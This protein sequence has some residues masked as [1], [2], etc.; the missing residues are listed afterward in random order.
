MVDGLDRFTDHFKGFSNAYVLIGGAA[1]DLWL[2]DHAL[3]FRATRDL[4]LVLLVEALTPPFFAR[5]W[6]FIR[7][8]QYRSLCETTG[9]PKF[10]RFSQPRQTGYPF[11]IELLTRNH[12][13]LPPGIK[14]TPIPAG[15]E[16]SS[17]SA[18]LMDDEYYQFVLNSRIVIKNVPLV[19]AN[20][21]IP[22][23]ARA[24]LDLTARRA[25][26]DHL[27]KGTDIKK[28][29]NDVFRLYRSLAPAERF[30]LP[31]RPRA[32]LQS[33]LDHFPPDSADWPAICE[34]VGS[35]PLPDTT[36]LLNHLRAIFDLEAKSPTQNPDGKRVY[37]N[38]D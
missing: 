22:M 20:C 27:V 14:L 5:F 21:L 37:T 18:I 30:T 11:M 24:W 26:A 17:L 15:E 1:C 25:A 13:N 19:S 10:Y 32:D 2:A 16:T 33:F 4:D 8:G 9:R 34:A 36:T 6:A 38:G 3:S 12:L 35:P 31:A 29:R 28:H 23:K 7:E